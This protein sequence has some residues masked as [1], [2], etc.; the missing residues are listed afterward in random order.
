M[1]T[2]APRTHR[3][4]VDYLRREVRPNHDGAS[5]ALDSLP[6]GRSFDTGAIGREL[7]LPMSQAPRVDDVLIR[8]GIA[9]EGSEG[10]VVIAGV[11]SASL[12]R[13]FETA[14]VLYCAVL[15]QCLGDSDARSEFLEHT[16]A[17]LCVLE[18]SRTASPALIPEW[19]AF[20]DSLEVRCR[21]PLLRTLISDVR[22]QMAFFIRPFAEEIGFGNSLDGFVILGDGIRDNDALIAGEGFQLAWRALDVE[23]ARVADGRSGARR[24]VGSGRQALGR[25][26]A[27]G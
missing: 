12:R 16:V 9:S 21:N 23:I 3:D 6:P 24:V 10:R 17:V 18:S 27:T 19:L 11:C 14:G 2:I 22:L 7:G 13:V 20:L 8:L 1:L 5:V 25:G 26:R 15:D 4:I